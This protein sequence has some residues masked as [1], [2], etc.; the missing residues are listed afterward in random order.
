MAA[1]MTEREFAEFNASRQAQYSAEQ[2]Q[3][4]RTEG[5]HNVETAPAQIRWQDVLSVKNLLADIRRQSI[6][7]NQLLAALLVVILI[8]A[9]FH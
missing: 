7:T 4:Q 2:Y 9:I 1:R 5:A 3:A 6:I 8:A